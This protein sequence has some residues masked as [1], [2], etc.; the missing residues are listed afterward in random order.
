[1]LCSIISPMQQDW[2]S[3]LPAIEF[4]INISRSEMTEYTPFLN[5]GHISQMF[6]WNDVTLDEYPSVQ[7][8]AQ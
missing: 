5:S 7:V 6:I 1:M 2:V 3:K 4:A 8:F